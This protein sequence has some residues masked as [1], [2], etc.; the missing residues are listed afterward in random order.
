M[1]SSIHIFCNC[2][3]S[4]LAVNS[5]QLRCWWHVSSLCVSICQQQLLLLLLLLLDCK[6]LLA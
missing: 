5:K 1:P 6:R 2:Y 3:S 4:S